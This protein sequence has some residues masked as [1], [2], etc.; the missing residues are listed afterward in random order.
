M[1]PHEQDTPLPTTQY[2]SIP[3]PLDYRD[4]G[5]KMSIYSAITRCNK[6]MRGGNEW[7]KIKGEEKFE[8]LNKPGSLYKRIAY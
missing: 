7:N 2:T 5:C 8:Q 1:A 6:S 4:F 3:S